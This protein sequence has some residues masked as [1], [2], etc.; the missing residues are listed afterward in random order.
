MLDPK[1]NQEW[2][3]GV[4]LQAVQH[5]FHRLLARL[6]SL[7]LW[8]HLWPPSLLYSSLT[9]YT[10]TPDARCYDALGAPPHIL[11]TRRK[12]RLFARQAR[13]FVFVVFTM[14]LTA[15]SP[16]N[17][18]RAP[19]GHCTP[20]WKEWCQLVPPTIDGIIIHCALRYC[21]CLPRPTACVNNHDSVVKNT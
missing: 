1:V 5:C 6:S 15:S 9:A 8:S 4:F 17:L 16:P 20:L 7:H 14:F 18:L 19:S 10:A 12:H 11:P 13:N 3:K 2:I 21:I